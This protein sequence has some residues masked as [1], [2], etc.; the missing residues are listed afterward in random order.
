LKKRLLFVVFILPFAAT[1]QQRPV[2]VE[3]PS[4]LKTGYAQFEFGAAHFQHQAFPLS[5][6]KGN[7]SKLGILRFRVALSEYVELETDG[8]LLDV[9]D[10][11]ERIPAFNSAITTTRNPTADIGDFSLWTKSMFLEEASSG[12]GLSLRFGVQLPNASNE[13]G[14]GI[15]EMNFFSSLLFQKHFAGMWTFNAGVGILGDPT[16]LSNQHD[17]FTYAFEYFIPFGE[18]TSCILQTAG[19]TGHFGVGIQR[20]ANSKL[21][22]EKTFGSLSLKAFGTINFSPID[23]AKGAEVTV[24]Y[25]FNVLDSAK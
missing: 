1:A 10:V 13:S 4:I 25:L 15:D 17:V 12:L 7:L 3:S 20:L 22:I 9:L 2:A 16:H 19:R 5:G 23:N 21:G 18:T 11:K 6:L 24:A 14:L 8:T